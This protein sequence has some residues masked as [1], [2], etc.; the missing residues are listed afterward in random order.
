MRRNEISFWL[1]FLVLNFLFFLPGYLVNTGTSSFFPVQGFLQGSV[2]E[3]IKTIFVRSNYDIFRLS[4][5]L[6]LVVMVYYMLRKKIRPG[7]YGWFAGIY[8]VITLAY[9]TYY[10]SF[11]KLYLIP[12]VSYNDITLLKLGIVN[13]LNGHWMKTAVMILLVSSVAYGLI[14]LVTRMIRMLHKLE[15]GIISKSLIIILV[16][17]ILINTV[18][19]GL[20][21][22]SNQAFQESF[23][24]IGTGV[25]SS[26]DARKNLLNFNVDGINRL[27]NYQGL[28]LK[29]KPDIYVLFIESYGKLLYDNEI[30]RAPYLRCMD[31]CETV[32]LGK[33][34]NV[35][36]GFSTSP[37]SGG[38][39]WISYSTVMFG[40]NVRNQ[41]TFN[42]LL[43]I[44]D[45]AR[46]NNLF[47]VLKQN[48]YKTYR[49][50]AMPQAPNL[51]VPWDTY[52]NFYSIDK[53]INFSDL[54]YTGRLYGFGPSP[55]DQ[56]SIHFAGRYMEQNSPGPHA[57]FFITQTTHNPFYSPVSLASDWQSLNE[58]KDSTAVHAS[59]FLKKPKISDYAKAVRYDLSAMVQ[60]ITQI[61]DS[62]AI[63][64]LIGDHQPP[65]ITNAGDG[66]ETPVHI[67]SRNSKFT[68]NFGQ[69][70]FKKGMRADE[71]A[72]P[73]RHEGIYSMFMREF[74]RLHGMDHSKLPGYLPYGI[75]VSGL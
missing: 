26:A 52:S 66:F 32:L 3:R 73:V 50:N 23:A 30:L 33:G 59:V 48:G 21:Y 57:L 28:N 38:Q 31:S 5:D 68:E 54:N 43:K 8:Y 56:Y 16:I 45:M 70:G 49:L 22:T 34:W 18:K 72:S 46:Y 25:K 63:F 24:L 58:D 1:L 42:S 19:S 29:S 47:R 9:I 36:S 14:W 13:I 6:F 67:I 65:V 27:M 7:F 40:Y 61:P 4:V 53:W 62:N 69:Y 44:P 11:E 64:L 2:Y 20:T 35:A 10:V 51:E 12:P 39:S 17:S 55:P 37:V 74:V 41:G 71:K 60:F 75:Q 15:W